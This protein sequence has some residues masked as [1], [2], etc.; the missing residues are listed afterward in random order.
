MTISGWITSETARAHVQQL[1]HESDAI[2]TGIGTVLADDCL[3]T[4]RT[5]LPR[6]RPLLRIVLDSQLRLPLDSKMVQSARGR[7]AGGG[8]IGGA[9]PSGARVLESRGVAGGDF[10][11]PRR[12]HGYARCRSKWLAEQKYLSLMIEAGSQSEL[13]GA[14]NRRG[15]QDFLL[16]RA[17]DSGRHA[18]AVRWPAESAGGGAWMP[19]ACDRTELHS[20]APDEF[21][22]EGYWSKRLECLQGS[23]KSWERWS[24][25]RPRGRGAPEDRI[26]R[27]C[28]EDMTEGASI[29][30]NGVC[31]T[32]VDLRPDVVL[33]G[34]GAG[35]SAAQ[36]SGRAERGCPGE[37]GAAAFA[38]GPAERA[39][40]AGPCGWHRRI[41]IAR[42]AGGR[43][44]VAE[45]ARSRGTGSLP[46]V[47]RD[48]SRSTA[49][50]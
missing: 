6:S 43:E 28:S 44:L 8:D 49:S 31:L 21:A 35:D 20:I 9:R 24:R 18:V 16:L 5:G 2:L 40:R 15:G 23:L 45:D 25:S 30:V 19:S 37:P 33:G 4:D 32:A 11:R 36:Q 46:G 22:V 12:A 29:A 50:A 3:L 10:R 7:C 39:H 27:G 14:R 42:G 47:S 38:D 1:R 34:P 48:R 41:S 13:V 26:A 17:E